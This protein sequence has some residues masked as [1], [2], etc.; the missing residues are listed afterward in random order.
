MQR[1]LGILLAALM[2]TAITFA[3]VPVRAAARTAQQAS[4]CASMKMDARLMDCV[5]QTPP[6]EEEKRCCAACPLFLAV[7]LNA[8]ET[9]FHPPL[10]EGRFVSALLVDYFRSDQPAVPPPRWLV[11]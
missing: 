8:E 3:S 10:G 11:C 5:H 2:A 9:L 7:L 6:S 4:C 1:L